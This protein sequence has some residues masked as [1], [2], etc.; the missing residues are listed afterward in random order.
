MAPDVA[1]AEV[2]N[3]VKALSPE[4]QRRMLSPKRTTR[5]AETCREHEANTKE[6]TESTRRRKNMSRL[7]GWVWI[8]RRRR[9][10]GI[11]RTTLDAR[12]AWRKR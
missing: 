8:V 3:G 1:A 2:K 6:K 4:D 7:P 12:N 5:A 11:T 10:R 9:R